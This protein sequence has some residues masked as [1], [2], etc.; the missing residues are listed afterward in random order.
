MGI[1][2]GWVE[3]V[4]SEGDFVTPFLLG[5]E[6]PLLGKE[7]DFIRPLLGQE[8][9]DDLVTPLLLLD[10]EGWEDLDPSEPNELRE[11][12]TDAEPAASLSTVLARTAATLLTTLGPKS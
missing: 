11:E 10:A 2:I 4:G 7:G 3:V 8:E 12:E 6:T 5:D 9:E 1:G